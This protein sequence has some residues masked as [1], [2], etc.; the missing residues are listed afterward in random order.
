[1]RVT[2]ILYIY[3]Y[4]CMWKYIEPNPLS[5]LQHCRSGEDELRWPTQHHTT[6][7][8]PSKS[9]SWWRDST[10]RSQRHKLTR[11]ETMITN[12]FM[13]LQR[14]R[15]I[16][17]CAVCWAL[18]FPLVLLM[19]LLLWWWSQ[20]ITCTSL[21]YIIEVVETTSLLTQPQGGAAASSLEKP[22]LDS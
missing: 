5:I 16:C 17:R 4:I 8:K 18:L 6:P 10:P 20:W 9:R 3:I 21:H 12:I 15:R 7:F 11:I 2:C 14:S 13:I 22:L 1:M 19:L